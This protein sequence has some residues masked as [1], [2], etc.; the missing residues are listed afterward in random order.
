MDEDERRRFAMQQEDATD[1]APAELDFESP[2]EEHGADDD[3]RDG[4]AALLDD[5]AHEEAVARR[6]PPDDPGP[7]AA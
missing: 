5:E 7:E 4:T 6:R 1:S 3:D 2:R